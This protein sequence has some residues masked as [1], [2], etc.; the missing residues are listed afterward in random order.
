MD[1]VK[2]DNYY[3]QKIIDN[4]EFVKEQMKDV[5]IEGLNANEILLDS[6]MFRMI[7]VSENAAGRI[8]K[9]EEKSWNYVINR[10]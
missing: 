2:T 10:T 3:V 4:L 6:M 9:L 7:Q 8:N 5:D 1:N